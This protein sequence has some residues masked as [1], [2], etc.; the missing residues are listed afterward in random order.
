MLLDDLLSPPLPRQPDQVGDLLD[1]ILGD[2]RR[3]RQGPA[4]PLPE[5]TPEVRD[6]LLRQLAQGTM[7]GL[8]Y[9]GNTLDK[10]GRAVRGLLGGRPEELAAL[11]PFSDT[12]GLTDINNAVSGRDL[13]EQYGLLNRNKP[14]F[15]PGD[16]AGFGVEM[17]LDPLSF[18]GGPVNALTKGGRAA[19]KAAGSIDEATGVMKKLKGLTPKAMADEIRAGE[20]GLLQFQTPWIPFLA[21]PVPIGKPLFAGSERAADLLEALHYGKYVGAPVRA[22]RGVFD[23]RVAGEFGPEMQRAADTAYEAAQNWKAGMQNLHLDLTA[24]HQEAAELYQTV[25]AG[26]AAETPFDEVLRQLNERQGPISLA[27]AADYF[28]AASD[29]ADPATIDAASRAFYHLSDKMRNMDD[30]IFRQLKEYGLD[31]NELQDL[32]VRHSARRHGGNRKVAEWVRE[33]NLFSANFPFAISRMPVLKNLPEGTKTVNEIASDPLFTAIRNKESIFEELIAPSLP[34]GAQV[35]ERVSTP[36]KGGKRKSARIL[37]S[38]ARET[39]RNAMRAKYKLLP[40]FATD[41]HLDQVI[42]YFSSAPIAILKQGDA[43]AKFDNLADAMQF[44]GG[45]RMKTII[46]SGKDQYSVYRPGGLFNR[47][48]LNDQLD[49]MLH[50]GRVMATMDTLH[51]I[52]SDPSIVNSAV[53]GTSLAELW[54]QM[55]LTDDGLVTLLTKQGKQVTDAAH[56]QQ[57]ASQLRIPEDIAKA[58]RRIMEAQKNPEVTFGFVKALDKYNNLFRAHLTTP[59]PAF[60]NRNL[61]SGQWANWATGMWSARSMI[62]AG[63][64]LKGKVPEGLENILAEIKT[65]E[66]AGFGKGATQGQLHSMF[67]GRAGSADV[68]IKGAWNYIKGGFSEGDATLLQRVNPFNVEG[69]FEVPLLGKGSARTDA[70]TY[71][72]AAMGERAADV[73]EFVNRVAPYIELRK[74]G[75]SPAAAAR[76]VRLVQYDYREMSKFDRTVGRRLIPFYG[77]WR[78]NLPAQIRELIDH[79][80]GRAAQTIRAANSL[81][82][83]KEGY[84]PNWLGEGLPIRLGADSSAYNLLSTVPPNEV[85]GT[86]TFISSSGLLPIEEAFN[87]VSF[88]GGKPDIK[89]IV[90]KLLAQTASP[91]STPAQMFTGEQFW[92]GRNLSDLHQFPTEN[93]QINFLLGQ[94]PATRAV[95]TARTVLDDRKTNIAKLLNILVGGIRSTQVDEERAMALEGRQILEDM[96]GGQ[97]DAGKVT[98]FYLKPDDIAEVSPDL[99]DQMSLYQAVMQQ[100]A[101]INKKRKAKQQ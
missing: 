83:N 81:R 49:Y 27:D 36:V 101:E 87:R 3:M 96:L 14:G 44:V 16:I 10:P 75:W 71:A 73:V 89:R 67:G 93:P 56:A 98:R 53:V 64:L 8:E 11:I 52:V 70:T 90:Q 72:P 86:A 30:T 58:T 69:G 5:L 37:T 18:I 46:K 91:F 100:L 94:T 99:I 34:S 4:I 80:G 66:V 32:F 79:P 41:E 12:L 88:E 76:K 82:E 23:Q 26:K 6:S 24:K 33:A 28:K 2:P 50:A 29:S 42:D 47:G 85:P 35:W 45:D 13:L 15:D 54:K 97:P 62:Q 40:S 22:L 55:G 17:A 60:H 31:V 78:K 25:M 43:V 61:I 1:R 48:T 65:Y 21:D 63:D 39:L 19:L 77:F 59:W 51:N 84:I 20:R 57:I 38:E 68:P 7:S 9:V 74:R 92:S 95:S